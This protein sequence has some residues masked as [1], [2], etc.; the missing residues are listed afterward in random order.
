MA[1]APVAFA[2][3]ALATTHAL[4]KVANRSLADKIAHYWLF[5][6]L[7][8]AVLF[9]PAAA[10]TLAGG[11]LL[12]RYPRTGRT[13]ASIGLALTSRAAAFIVCA[14][15]ADSLDDSYDDGTRWVAHLPPLGA[16]V[17]AV[18][19]VLLITENAYTDRILWS[20]Q[21][22]TARRDTPQPPTGQ[23]SPQLH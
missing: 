23:A 4:D 1:A 10:L 7:A 11:W 22:S 9:I 6:L 18:P 12:R 17:F 20:A 8:G 14:C 3:V 2:A 5:T 13:T 19:F 16:A 15:F 21:L